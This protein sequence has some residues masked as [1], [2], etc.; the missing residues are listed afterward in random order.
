MSAA[1]GAPAA[2]P[3]LLN[4]YAHAFHRPEQPRRPA[5]SLPQTL[6]VSH[7]CPRAC[8]HPSCRAASH[9]PPCFFPSTSIAMQA[10][11]PLLRRL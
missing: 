6:S 3:A 8:C 9:A 7:S 5:P 1:R 11:E 10:I 4:G 2:A